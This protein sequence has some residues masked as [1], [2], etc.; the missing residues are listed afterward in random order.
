MENITSSGELKEAIYLLEAQQSV[1]AMQLREQLFLISESLKPANLIANTLNEMK[2]SPNFANNAI[3]AAIGL[4]AGYL[5]RKAVIRESDSN[6][7]KLLGT[8]IQLGIT[9][10]VALHP[11]NIITFGKFIFQNIFRKTNYT[12]P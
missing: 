10:F 3:S 2:S 7:R 12:R 8:V 9:N 6:F 4:T 5:S 1:H 11:D